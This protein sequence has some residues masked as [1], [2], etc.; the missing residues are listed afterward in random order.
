MSTILN[1][2][3]KLKLES[4]YIWIEQI[5]M[6]KLKAMLKGK[7]LTVLKSLKYCSRFH[8]FLLFVVCH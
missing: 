4:R 6:K 7:E 5:V 3:Y 8:L 2:K 1:I